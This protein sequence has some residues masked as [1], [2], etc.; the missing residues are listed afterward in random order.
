MPS[1]R[2]PVGK[3]TPSM[4]SQVIVHAVEADNITCLELGIVRDEFPCRMLI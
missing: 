4:V 3:G 2:R 1:N